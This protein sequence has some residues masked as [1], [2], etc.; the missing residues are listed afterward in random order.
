M[1]RLVLAPLMLVFLLS[2]SASRIT[3]CLHGHGTCNR[4]DEPWCVVEWHTTE[5]SEV[6][7]CFP[8]CDSCWTVLTPETRLP[9]YKEMM[10]DWHRQAVIFGYWTPDYDRDLDNQWQQIHVA[11]LEGK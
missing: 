10:S 4:C 1:K 7:G 2:C 8:L 5:Y 9:F 11:V 3:G 6:S